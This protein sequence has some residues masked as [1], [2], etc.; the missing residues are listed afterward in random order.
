[1]IIFIIFV[2]I[3]ISRFVTETFSLFFS[4]LIAYFYKFAIS[5]NLIKK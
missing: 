5:V 2:S 1:M 3:A 4:K